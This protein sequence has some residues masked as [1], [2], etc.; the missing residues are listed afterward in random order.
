MKYNYNK[1]PGRELLPVDI[2]LAPEWWN[3]NERVIFDRD[4]LYKYG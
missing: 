1:L 3:K 4:L 2:V